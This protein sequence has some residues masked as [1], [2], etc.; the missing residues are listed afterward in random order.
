MSKIELSKTMS[1]EEYKQAHRPI[2][3]SDPVKQQILLR[4]QID[5]DQHLEKVWRAEYDAFIT[6]NYQL[7]NNVR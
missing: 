2:E 1:F 7:L 5:I 4:Y 6:G 3:I